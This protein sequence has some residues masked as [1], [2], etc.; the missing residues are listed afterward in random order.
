MKDDEPDETGGA[1]RRVHDF[2]IPQPKEEYGPHIKMMLNLSTTTGNDVEVV[3]G[4][5]DYE[6]KFSAQKS[7]LL[8]GSQL[9]DF[10][11]ALQYYREKLK[12]YNK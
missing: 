6:N 11:T 4:Y 8:R 3:L 2:E 1:I 12:E 10:I 7:F 9:D 5:L